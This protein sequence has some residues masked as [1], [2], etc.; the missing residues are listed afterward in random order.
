[1]WIDRT[2]GGQRNGDVG[3]EDGREDGTYRG[4]GDV[5]EVGRNAGRVDDIVERELVNQRAGLE[6]QRERL[7]IWISETLYQATAQSQANSPGQC[8]Q[9]HL[10]QLYEEIVSNFGLVLAKLP[11]W[12]VA[13]M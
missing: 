5:G 8:R 6:Q 10:Q 2:K 1:M 12:R 11:S 9:K 13:R 4:A 3:K 7:E